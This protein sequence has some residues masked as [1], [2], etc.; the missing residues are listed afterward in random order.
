MAEWNKTKRIIKKERKRI[1]NITRKR[2]IAKDN[3]LQSI[4]KKRWKAWKNKV[5][6][7]CPSSSS[8]I[9]EAINYCLVIGYSK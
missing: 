6:L 3:W 1:K 5:I 4:W 8:S 2:R 9:I 7:K